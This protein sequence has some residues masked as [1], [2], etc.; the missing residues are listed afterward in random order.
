MTGLADKPAEQ[1][2]RSLLKAFT[3]RATGSLDTFVLAY[4]FTGHAKVAVAISMT[5]VVTKI[6]LYYIH[7]RV[8]TRIT[9]GQQER[10]SAKEPVAA[11]D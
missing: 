1:A 6:V 7:E 4:L 10:G 2:R 8:W 11:R 9:F 5:E 3:W